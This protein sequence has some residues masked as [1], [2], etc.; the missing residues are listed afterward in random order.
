MKKK[1]REIHLEWNLSNDTHLLKKL[2]KQIDALSFDSV[3]QVL[4]TI[5]N[6]DKTIFHQDNFLPCMVLNKHDMKAACTP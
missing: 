6:I 3:L 2:V 5:S 4:S 1:G